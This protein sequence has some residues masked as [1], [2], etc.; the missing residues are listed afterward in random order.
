LTF[1]PNCG[2]QLSA[3]NIHT[4][5]PVL[6][7]VNVAIEEAI[8]TRIGDA[9]GSERKRLHRLFRM[10]LTAELRERLR[11]KSWKNID[12]SQLDE[13]LSVVTEWSKRYKEKN[14]A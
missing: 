3:T 13:A 6:A 2:H 1:C 5:D 14:S 12:Q 4:S 9:D 7:K 10:W 8:S 11:L